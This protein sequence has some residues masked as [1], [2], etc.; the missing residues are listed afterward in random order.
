MQQ[1]AIQEL[2]FPTEQPTLNVSHFATVADERL[3]AV[4]RFIKVQQ[5]QAGGCPR[6]EVDSVNIQ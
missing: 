3:L 5:R 6:G 4:Q 2:R 1:I